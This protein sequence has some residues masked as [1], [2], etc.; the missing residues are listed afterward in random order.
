MIVCAIIITIFVAAL[1]SVNEHNRNQ[2]VMFVLL[3]TS[4][5]GYSETLV[6]SSVAL[7]T[8]QEDIGL[9]FGLMS[10]IRNGGAAVASKSS[11]LSKGSFFTGQSNHLKLLFTPLSYPTSLQFICL[12]MLFLQH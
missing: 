5:V 8:D 6:L 1:A 12:N 11:L 3:A 2:S 9:S 7:V 10:S 4:A